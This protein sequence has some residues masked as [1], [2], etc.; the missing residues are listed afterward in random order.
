MSEESREGGRG[1]GMAA[2]GNDDIRDRGGYS[3]KEATSGLFWA[4]TSRWICGG[5]YYRSETAMARLRRRFETG[6]GGGGSKQA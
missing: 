2:V 5:P 4:E 3:S 1:R 6:G